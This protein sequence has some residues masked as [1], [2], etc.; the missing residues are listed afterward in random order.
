VLIAD[1]RA[2]YG[3]AREM[4]AGAQALAE[5][6]WP[7]ALTLL[8]EAQPGLTWDLGD[9][10]GT[11]ALRVPDHDVT[12]DLLRRTG[13]LAV[14]SANLT[15]APPAT[16]VTDAMAQL[17]G[18]AEVYLDAGPT[19]GPVPS[20]IVDA[21]TL[22]VLR[23]GAISLARL[24]EVAPVTAD[25]DVLTA[26]AQNQ[27]SALEDTDAQDQDPASEGT[28]AADRTGAGSAASGPASSGSGPTEPGA[29]EPGPGGTW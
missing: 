24:R 17:G 3:L 21:R 20:T 5:T 18:K 19:P 13:P 28:G 12:R 14:S 1:A 4:S 15:G 7:G 2:V 6:F 11:V 16:T 22:R 27:G 9:T 29:S 23:A 10:G 25:D 26:D 8:V